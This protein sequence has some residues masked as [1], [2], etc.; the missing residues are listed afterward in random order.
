MKRTVEFFEFQE[1]PWYSREYCRSDRKKVCQSCGSKRDLT[2]SHP[3]MLDV[4]YE[5]H[6][7]LCQGVRGRLAI[8]NKIHSETKLV[9]RTP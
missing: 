6:E 3:P 2:G 9:S 8:H 1:I 7:T 5:A 4:G